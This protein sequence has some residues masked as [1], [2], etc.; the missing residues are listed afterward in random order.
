[1]AT[2]AE[3]IQTDYSYDAANETYARSSSSIRRLGYAA[4]HTEVDRQEVLA[5]HEL[6]FSDF[7]TAVEEMLKTDPEFRNLFDIDN[8]RTHQVKDGHVLS[9]YGDPMVWLLQNGVISSEQ[10]TQVNKDLEAQVIRD[11]CDVRLAK[12]ID[13]LQPG[14]TIWGLSMDPKLQLRL[15]PKTYKGKLGYK[16]GLM[17]IQTYSKVDEQTLVAASFSVDKSDEQIWREIVA[18]EGMNIPAGVDLNTW[19][20]YAQ[21]IEASSEQAK[22]LVLKLRAKFYQRIGS[23]HERYS[24]NQF[25]STHINLVR[26]LFETYYVPLAQATY[27]GRNNQTLQTFALSL[28]NKNIDNIKAEV[29]RQLIKIANSDNFDDEATAT[30]DAIIRYATVEEL[31]K[32]LTAKVRK[33][34]AAVLQPL[35]THGGYRQT[36][37]PEQIHHL[38]AAN[39]QA[40]VQAG[41]SYGGCP[42]NIELSDAS[43]TVL[44]TNVVNE[45][46]DQLNRQQAYGGKDTQK[47]CEYISKECPL[48]GAKGVR[49]KAETLSDGRKRVSGKCG[50]VKIYS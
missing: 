17:Y 49:T 21:E 14:Q 42:G 47:D 36:F 11:K 15:Y 4:L 23:S 6:A 1:M 35:L 28:L 19:L 27:A 29:K 34:G 50:C 33:A 20:D 46:G 41:R 5:A 32:G 39:V 48:C 38:V 44:L 3:T 40:G 45:L 13:T 10:A 18:E 24:I 12:R 22:A 8:E 9:A 2:T 16:D 31:R 37:N 26:Q 25:V 7:V 30:M 43:N